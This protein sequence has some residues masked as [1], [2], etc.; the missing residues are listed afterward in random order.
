[1]LSLKESAAT[2]FLSIKVFKIFTVIWMLTVYMTACI[3]K[4]LCLGLFRHA[5]ARG[6][7]RCLPFQIFLLKQNT[8]I[9]LG[10]KFLQKLWKSE[11]STNSLF[12]VFLETK[13]ICICW[14]SG[15]LYEPWNQNAIHYLTFW[16]PSRPSAR[17]YIKYHKVMI[18]RNSFSPGLLWKYI[19]C[20]TPCFSII[21]LGS[22]GRQD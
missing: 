22:P 17:F 12:S 11:R 4:C 2:A 9:N 1:M 18:N 21:I 14:I 16:V 19:S 5:M 10:L 13:V 3:H 8:S 20:L 6:V 15:M 7:D